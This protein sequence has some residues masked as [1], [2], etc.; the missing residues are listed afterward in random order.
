MKLKF[1][2]KKKYIPLDDLEVYKLA[3]ELSKYSWQVYKEFDW[4]TKKIM[5]DQ[6]ISAIDSVGA[7]I[8]EG[9][10]RYHYLEK[11][12]FFYTARASLAEAVNHWLELLRERDKFKEDVYKEIRNIAD[13]ISLKLQNFISALYKA[14]NSFK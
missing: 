14:K 2:E 12:K 6:F 9:Y 8:A 13:K 11:I 7:N 1:M 4:Q 3:R 10:S 5:G